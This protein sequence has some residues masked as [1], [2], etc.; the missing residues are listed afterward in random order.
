M[1]NSRKHP[2]N[3]EINARP[4]GCAFRYAGSI[5]CYRDVSP[6]YS[7]ASCAP[8]RLIAGGMESRLR[9]AGHAHGASSGG[10]GGNRVIVRY[11]EFRFNLICAEKWPSATE[12][13]FQPCTCKLRGNHCGQ[14]QSCVKSRV[15]DSR[16][17]GY[18][19][20]HDAGTTTRVCRERQI[21]EVEPAESSQPARKG[22]RKDFDDTRTN[23]EN[24]QLL[25]RKRLREIELQADDGEIHRDEERK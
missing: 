11:G 2:S 24:E 16:I 17:E 19:G 21:N 18:A 23:K 8:V 1:A 13:V 4:G 10:S 14:H 5:E 15:N 7:E 22:N 12:H 20:Q 25:P 6:G 9:R 3:G